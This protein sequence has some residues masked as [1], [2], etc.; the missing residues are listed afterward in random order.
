[1]FR[2]KEEDFRN[3]TFFF[4]L[5]FKKGYNILFNCQYNKN[6]KGIICSANEDYNKLINYLIVIAHRFVL[7]FLT[8][9]I[10]YVSI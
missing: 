1:M 10:T 5:K 2:R 6:N 9:T 4:K 8:E 7:V 3:Q